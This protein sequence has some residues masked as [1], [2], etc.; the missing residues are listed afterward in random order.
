[1]DRS[2]RHL[3]DYLADQKR[4]RTQRKPLFHRT[5]SKRTLTLKVQGIRHK[6]QGIRL[7]F[8]PCALSLKLKTILSLRKLNRLALE[9][10]ILQA[11]EKAVLVDVIQQDQTEKQ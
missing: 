10:Y 1:M 9:R 4:S 6:E 5:C 8:M 11:E 2:I 3:S 7:S